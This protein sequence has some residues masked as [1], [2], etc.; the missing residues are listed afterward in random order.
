VR[1]DGLAD[2]ELAAELRGATARR[3]TASGRGTHVRAY[4]PRRTAVCRRS[5][6]CVTPWSA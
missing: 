3:H 6:R 1:L 5:T 2:R 4:V